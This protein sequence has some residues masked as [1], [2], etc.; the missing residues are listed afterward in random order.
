M[1]WIKSIKDGLRICKKYLKSKNNLFSHIFVCSLRLPS[2]CFP[3]PPSLSLSNWIIFLI[4]DFSRFVTFLLTCSKLHIAWHDNWRNAKPVCTT[5]K[6][7]TSCS[8]PNRISFGS[9]LSFF[10]THLWMCAALQF[11]FW[12]CAVD[13][14]A[15]LSCLC[16]TWGWKLLWWMSLTPM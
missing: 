3:L 7:R 16:A 12:Y 8:S 4:A 14:C 9:T 6:M 1:L 15:A 2:V 13:N 10:L 11:N 5:C